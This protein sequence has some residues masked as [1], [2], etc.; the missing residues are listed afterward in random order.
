MKNPWSLPDFSCKCRPLG[1]WTINVDVEVQFRV[2][3]PL[4]VADLWWLITSHVGNIL[5][6]AIVLKNV[7]LG[8]CVQSSFFE[9][10]P[11]RT[12]ET[13]IC[14]IPCIFFIIGIHAEKERL[15]LQPD[16]IVFW[17]FRTKMKRLGQAFLF[18]WKLTLQTKISHASTLRRRQTTSTVATWIALR[19]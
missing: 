2:G 12:S 15:I 6:M 8:A 3:S 18:E 13:P 14:S 7:D 1:N 5:S 16:F 19:M 4:H 17:R 10:T 9:V 11:S